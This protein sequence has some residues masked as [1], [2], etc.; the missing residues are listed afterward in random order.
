M[1]RE[2]S[3]LDQVIIASP[4]HVPWTEMK[5]D[6][7]VR[8][9]DSCRL[10][11]YNLSA[12]SQNDAENLIRQKEGRLCATFYRRRDGTIL[13]RDCPVGL[14]MVRRSIA[15]GLSA[16]G[17]VLMFFISIGASLIGAPQTSMRL[18]RA[19]PFAAICEMLSPAPPAGIPMGRIAGVL[20]APGKAVVPSNVPPSRQILG[21]VRRSSLPTGSNGGR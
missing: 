18:R 3:L 1:A 7:R 11:V 10:N 20:S 13:T 16:V 2:V 8:F 12:M 17:V 15:R 19:Q 4:C 21:V 5:G 6:D 9:C 14:R